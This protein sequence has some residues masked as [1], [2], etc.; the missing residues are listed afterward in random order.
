M[1]GGEGLAEE[2][3]PLAAAR[4][5]LAGERAWVVGGAVRDRLLGRAGAPD[6]DLAVDGDVR[7]V[8]RR[9]ARATGAASF[10]LSGTHGAWRVAAR[11]GAWQVDVVALQGGSLEADLAARDLTLNAMAQPLAG[12]EIVDPHGGRED[13]AARRVRM[14]S[15][16]AFDRDPLRVLRV[17][18]LA[19]ELGFTVEPATRAAARARAPRVG[20]VPAERVFGELR[21]VVGADDALRGMAL[22]DELALM[23]AVLPELDALRGVE[24]S[25]YHHRDVFGHTLEVLEMAIG[26]ERDPADPLGDDLAEGVRALLAEPLADELTRGGALRWAALLHDAA[27]PR[28]RVELPGG[29][30]GFPHHDSIGAELARSAL[31]RLRTS[32]RLRAHVAAMTRHHLRVGFLVR[33]APLDRRAVHRYLVATAPVAIDVTLLTVADRL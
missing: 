7:A 6:V 29:R 20:G 8:A 19:C 21:R 9:L 5:A 13:L 18:R 3:A 25:A 14:V 11:D 23:P 33:E 4:G 16:A 27:K 2:A 30:I 24:Q 22:L 32:E 17:A 10:E 26:L 12:G 1:S 15:P 31:A 28:T